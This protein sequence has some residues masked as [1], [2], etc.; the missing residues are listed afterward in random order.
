MCE[1]L[2][3]AVLKTAIPERVSGVRIPLPPPAFL[4]FYQ[5][6]AFRADL[7]CAIRVVVCKGL[8]T[9]FCG[10]VGIVEDVSEVF[11]HQVTAE[12]HEFIG[13]CGSLN[14][15]LIDASGNFREWATRRASSFAVYGSWRWVNK[16]HWILS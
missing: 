12:D 9:D 7:P 6:L 8:E 5:Q 11:F 14:R 10:G 16:K 2:K 15:N 3:Q 4:L 1:R 13:P